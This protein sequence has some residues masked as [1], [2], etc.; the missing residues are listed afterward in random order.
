MAERRPQCGGHRGSVRTGESGGRTG[1]IP[2]RPR[3]SPAG[4]SGIDRRRCALLPAIGTDP[5]RSRFNDD[6]GTMSSSTAYA[7]DTLA[8]A[9]GQAAR[10]VADHLLALQDSGGYWCADLTADTT[11]ESDYIL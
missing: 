3:L 9:A 6:F 1:G 2:A 8:S 7:Q 11:L 5:G 10:R 4:R